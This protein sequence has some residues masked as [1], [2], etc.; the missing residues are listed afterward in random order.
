MKLVIL[1]SMMLFL[2]DPV[3]YNCK[4]NLAVY[5]AF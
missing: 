1:I 5:N 3:G 4:K 2:I